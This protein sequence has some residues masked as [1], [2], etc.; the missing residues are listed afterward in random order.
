MAAIAPVPTETAARR[1]WPFLHLCRKAHSSTIES[2]AGV[3]RRSVENR[4]AFSTNGLRCSADKA[5]P[6]ST[7]RATG[8]GLRATGYGL[9]AAGCSGFFIQNLQAGESPRSAGRAPVS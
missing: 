3:W 7:L 5:S 9:R 6:P 8:Y 2:P 4:A 1:S